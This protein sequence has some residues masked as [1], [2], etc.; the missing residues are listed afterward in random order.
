MLDKTKRYA[1]TIQQEYGLDA[2]GQIGDISGY[3]IA[4]VVAAVMITIG[5][6]IVNEL[7][8]QVTEGSTAE[9]VTEKAEEG[10]ETFGDF[11][12][13]IAIV[14]AAAVIMA[15]LVNRFMAKR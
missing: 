7:G 13:I 12:P 4:F 8:G 3:A 1:K 15:L 5:A 2:K 9:S 14:A 10:F 11:L 6:T